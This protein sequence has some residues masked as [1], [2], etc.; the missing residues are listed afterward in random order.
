VS[1]E[2]KPLQPLFAAEAS[3]ID[4]RRPLDAQGVREFDA[5]MDRYG[6]LVF[7]K[8]PLDEDQQIAFARSLGKL[9]MGLKKVRN[10]PS[11]FK[12]EDLIDIGNLDEKGQV[13]ARDHRKM[14][15]QI[16]NQLWHSD[17]SFQRPKAKYSM[18]SAV[19]V[20]PTGGETEY[21]D[22]RAAYDALP[23]AVKAEIAGLSAQHHALHTRIMLGETYTE[24]ER[25][26]MPPVDWPLVQT[27]PGSKRKILF[28]GVHAT[29]I[30]GWMLAE[31]RIM[32]ADLLEHATQRRFVYTHEWR[33]GDFV[34]WDNR[35]MLHRGRR[36]DLS[37]RRELRRSTTQDLDSAIEKAA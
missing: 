28:V 9:D 23:D 27:H 12:H 32:L 24:E 22:L 11:R 35:C 37:Q 3:G 36:Y 10:L 8:Q 25:N 1:L 29:H 16:A 13:A 5:A 26:V 31:G 33:A 19:E 14:I 15:S 18:L 20:P 30:H 4:L 2:L 17:S 34:V 6:V 21:A 7:R